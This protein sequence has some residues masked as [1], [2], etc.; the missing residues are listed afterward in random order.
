MLFYNY[1]R[2]VKHF[3]RISG[4]QPMPLLLDLLPK[5]KDL[6]HLSTLV[7]SCSGE[8]GSFLPNLL[9][10]VLVFCVFFVLCCPF[11]F[12][13][14]FVCRLIYG[15]S[16]PL[17]YLSIFLATFYLI[18]TFRHMFLC[19][20]VKNLTVLSYQLYIRVSYEKKNVVLCTQA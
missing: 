13:H 17:W 5:V 4:F 14:C 16:W 11:S 15:F 10:S 8:W 20:R 12:A 6:N 1:N 18:I 2:L 3:R 7:F 9:F 19:I